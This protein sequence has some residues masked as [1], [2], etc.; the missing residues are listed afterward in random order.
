MIAFR[1][2]LAPALLAV[3]LALI[4]LLGFPGGSRDAFGAAQTGATVEVQVVDFAFEPAM[5][6]IE[7]GATVAT[8]T[9]LADAIVSNQGSHN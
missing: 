4:P 2:H 9:E 5:V 3:V 8:L 1:R 6:M 7:V